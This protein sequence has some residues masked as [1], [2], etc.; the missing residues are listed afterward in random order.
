MPKTGVPEEVAALR[1]FE[2]APLEKV[3]PVF[4]IVT[5]KMRVR[6]AAGAHAG[7]ASPKKKRH[8]A[9]EAGEPR[10]GSEAE[11]SGSNARISA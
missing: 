8:T 2:E 9:K 11:P 5:E 10:P 7:D 6:L 1:F 4:N 3:K